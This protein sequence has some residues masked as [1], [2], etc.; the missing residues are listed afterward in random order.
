MKL[1]RPLGFHPYLP[2]RHS[3]AE[4]DNSR[5]IAVLESGGMCLGQD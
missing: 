5:E 1:I 4:S 2:K 3:G